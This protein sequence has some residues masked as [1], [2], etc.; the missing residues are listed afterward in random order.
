MR[1][2]MLL[3]KLDELLRNSYDVKKVLSRLFYQN[4]IFPFCQFIGKSAF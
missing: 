3:L 1:K 2:I 4:Y